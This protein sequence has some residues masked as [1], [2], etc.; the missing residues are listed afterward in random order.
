MSGAS[1]VLTAAQVEALRIA[2]R[3]HLAPRFRVKVD[4]VLIRMQALGWPAVVRETLRLPAL[5]HHYF[6]AGTSAADDVLASWHAY[7]LAVDVVHATQLWDAPAAFWQALGA[8]AEAEGCAWGGR[9][10]HP[11]DSPHLQFGPGMRVSPSDRARTLR[12]HGGNYAVWE[13][14]GAVGPASSERIAPTL[15]SP[16]APYAPTEG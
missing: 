12:A 5:Q 14:V 3:A 4:A 1:G 6:A 13:A 9:W 15:A 7:G 16:F 2:D 8:C 11:T 10:R